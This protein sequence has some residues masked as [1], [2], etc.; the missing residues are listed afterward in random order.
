MDQSKG[1]NDLIAQGKPPRGSKRIVLSV[2]GAVV[3]A[4]VGLVG[5]QALFGSPSLDEYAAGKKGVAFSDP[6][7]SFSVTFPAEPERTEQSTPLDDGREVK[8]TMYMVDEGDYVFS[9]GVT[10]IP[11]DTPFSLEGAAQGAVDAVKGKLVSSSPRNLGQFE[12]LYFEIDAEGTTISQWGIRAGSRFY[13]VQTV[14][15][16][17]GDKSA[18]RFFES[19]SIK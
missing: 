3:G 9:L 11:S 15:V 10:E 16:P 12:G 13:Q 6:G 1:P 2:L 17:Y 4:V 19:L 7:G 14:G 5:W 18:S 8:T